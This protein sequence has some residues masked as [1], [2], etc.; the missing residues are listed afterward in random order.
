MIPHEQVFQFGPFTF[1]RREG[2]YRGDAPVPLRHLERQLL[3]CLLDRAGEIV[4][5]EE[6]VAA[7]WPET[8]VAENTLSVQVRRLRISLKDTKKPHKLLKAYPRMGYML[9]ADQARRGA[10]VLPKGKSVGDK[11]RFIRDVT[12]PDG[13]IMA[14]G[15]RFEKIWEIQNVA[16][17]PWT[18]RMLRRVGACS[19]PG[20]LISDPENP[21]PDTKPGELCLVRM[22][23]TAPSQPASYYAAWKMVNEEGNEALPSQS[24]LFV[25]IDVVQDHV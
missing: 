17:R 22:W 7:V 8:H 24:P 12:I 9:V 21:I 11:S 5:K 18:H 13:T 16:S 10:A 15:T 3:K 23:L 6:L 14:P 20:R 1:S 19:G 2:L 4:R 25:A